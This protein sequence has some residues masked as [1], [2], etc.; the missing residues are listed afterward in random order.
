MASGIDKENLTA[1]LSAIQSQK[2]PSQGIT[3]RDR[4]LRSK[5]LGPGGLDA[6]QNSSGNRRKVR[7]YSPDIQNN[8]LNVRRDVVLSCVSTEIYT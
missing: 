6:L 8:S 1:D 2:N 3:A 5:S 7:C 4:K